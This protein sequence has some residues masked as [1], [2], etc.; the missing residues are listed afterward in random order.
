[1]TP[2]TADRADSPELLL[3]LTVVV[4]AEEVATLVAPDVTEP[5]AFRISIFIASTTSPTVR[6]RPSAATS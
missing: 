3:L 1:M 4:G 6:V 2:P 5:P